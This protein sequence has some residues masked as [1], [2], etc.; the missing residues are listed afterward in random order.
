MK[1]V[2]ELRPVCLC[3]ECFN[4]YAEPYLNRTLTES[5]YYSLLMLFLEGYCPRGSYRP[6]LRPV[7]R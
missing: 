3:G 4:L 5:E 7:K 6:K 2:T 1:P